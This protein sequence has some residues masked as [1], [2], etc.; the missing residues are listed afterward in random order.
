MDRITTLLNS[1][2]C[3]LNTDG[4]G[5]PPILD[6][7]NNQVTFYATLGVVDSDPTIY[8]LRYDS[9]TKQHVGGPVLAGPQ[10][11]RGHLPDLSGDAEQLAHHRDEHPADDGGHADLQVLAVRHHRRP[12]LGMVDTRRWPRR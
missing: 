4:T 9:A 2:I 5:Q 7:Q 1:Q 3:L 6:G 12:T 10:R 11:R 8:R